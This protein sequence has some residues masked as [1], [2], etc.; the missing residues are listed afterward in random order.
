MTIGTG[1][2]RSEV[3]L[4]GGGHVHVQVLAKLAMEPIDGA[5]VTVV[6]DH[7]IAVYSGM[8]PGFIAGQYSAEELEI[9]VVPLARRAGANV[10][11]ARATHLDVKQRRLHVVGRPP[12]R[13]DY[14]SIN[15][16]STVAGLETPGVR[17]LAVPSRPIGE[18]VRRMEDVLR[19]AE[20]SSDRP[21][22]VV[23]VGAGAGGVEVAF[24]L[25]Q[26]LRKRCAGGVR[27]SIVHSGDRLLGTYPKKL[28]RR[29]TALAVER[30]IETLPN[31]VV[32]AIEPGCVVF[33]DGEPLDAD[34]VFWVTGASGHSFFRDS[35]LPT[36]AR[37]F[38]KTSPELL[39]EGRGDVFAVGDCA[40]LTDYP[41][42]PKAG[43]YAV[44]E[45]PYLVDNLRAAVRGTALRRYEPQSDFLTL[46]NLGDGTAIGA[47]WS[48]VIEGAWV[49]SLKDSI[50]RRFMR[51]FRV[52]ESTG[53]LTEHFASAPVMDEE[54]PCGGC[55][56][57]VGQSVLTRALERLPKP[58]A[59]SSVTLGLDAADDAAAFKT[60]SGD[61]V[62]TSVDAFRAFLDDPHL[63]AKVAAV[64]AASDLFAKGAEPKHALAL[65]AV[66][67]E[68]SPEDAEEL[69]FQV[70]SG[71]RSVFDEMGV[72]LT[73]GHTTTAPEL[74]VG[75][76][77]DGTTTAPLLTMDGLEPGMALVSSKPLGTG[78]VLA[79]DM[80]GRARGEWLEATLASML[81]SNAEA[82]SEAR[83]FGATAATDVTGFGLAGHLHAMLE[84]AG[85]SAT[86][87]LSRIVALPG[88]VELNAEGFRSTAHAENVKVKR[89]FKIES[90]AAS[91]RRLE[92]LFDPQTSGG[93]LVGLEPDAAA[94]MVSR[95]NERGHRA[96]VIG[97]VEPPRADG[98]VIRVVANP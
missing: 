47:K 65:V 45:G 46:L 25:D 41:D 39:L 1:A 76:A 77:V 57:K 84:R 40:T 59:D 43:V 80:R 62:V 87:D 2:R 98:A 56:A 60:P 93:L 68:L 7:P 27:I 54:M 22:S 33:D 36:D 92:L 94:S 42:T 74:L 4:V 14:A 96:A 71:A 30:G 10:V 66:P 64:N 61:L 63:V 18:L 8:V 97:N 90:S 13:Y 23:V 21:L 17:E 32:R 9:D 82:A 91:H 83:R 49:M 86:L 48:R 44:R 81:Q 28:S 5:R 6:L 15:I 79:A 67:V 37:G 16:G 38:A 11:L 75:F 19:R 34:T 88:A 12:L 31:T 50:D 35:G 69:L 73:G 58:A 89:A 55:A 26:R 78:V 20:L 3:V 24:T 85:A 29:V 51:R 53:A 70:M 72:T 95:L 52:L